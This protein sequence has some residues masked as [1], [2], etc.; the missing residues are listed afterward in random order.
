M[1][2]ETD[3]Q[4]EA[5]YAIRGGPGA[6]NLKDVLAA[7]GFLGSLEEPRERPARSPASAADASEKSTTVTPPTEAV[8]AGHHDSRVTIVSDGQKTTHH[9]DGSVETH[10]LSG[11]EQAELLAVLSLARKA[12]GM[13]R[14]ASADDEPI[15]P[16]DDVTH[17]PE[18]SG[19]SG[20]VVIRG[21]TLNIGKVAGG[22]IHRD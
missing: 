16:S 18:V 17:I 19:A 8:R 3:P 20:S 22:N 1:S 5:R 11:D 21:N 6:Y 4:H 7:S 9:G 13:A 14:A 2:A 12:R 15:D 10:E